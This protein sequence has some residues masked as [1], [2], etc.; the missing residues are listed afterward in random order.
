M[1]RSS[2][3]EL[4]SESINRF[5]HRIAIEWRGTRISYDELETRANEIATRLISAGAGKGLRCC[6]KTAFMSF[7]R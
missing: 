4:L 2:I 7:R 3:L 6:W 1:N 5:R